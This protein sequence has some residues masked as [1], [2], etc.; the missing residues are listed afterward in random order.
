MRGYRKGLTRTS[1]AGVAALVLLGLA[2]ASCTVPTEPLGGAGQDEERRYVWLQ[3][4]HTFNVEAGEEDAP[5]FP[6]NWIEFRARDVFTF[7][8]PDDLVNRPV[9][10]I[11][12]FIGD[13]RS[14]TIRVFFDY[15]WYSPPAEC[16]STELEC[17]TEQIEVDGKQAT[18]L[19]GRMRDHEGN[20]FF[21]AMVYVPEVKRDPY[22]EDIWD[23]LSLFATSV[24]EQE[25][26]V[27]E[28]IVRSVDFID[29]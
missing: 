29:S 16:R 11:D 8:G 15:G 9:Q 4:Q 20:A 25:R 2:G 14:Q 19:R 21:I 23:R 17:E 5:A 7:M 24:Q 10:G 28:L 22:F 27:L 26:D 6:P 1:G 18:L 13:Y 12:S 3:E